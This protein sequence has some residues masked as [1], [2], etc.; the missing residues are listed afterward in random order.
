MSF[1]HARRAF[2]GVIVVAFACG[3][4][5]VA[6]D[7][8]QG[9]GGSSA[10][11]AGG[12][13]VG[14]GGVG[15]GAGTSGAGAAGTAGKGGGAGA[16]SG[17]AGGAGAGGSAGKAGAG[18]SAPLVCDPRFAFSPSKPAPGVPFQVS[19]TDT[20]PYTNVAMLVTGP[21][22]PATSWVGVSGSYTWTWAVTGHAAGVSTFT[23]QKDATAPGKG[24]TLGTCQVEV[25]APGT[26]GSG[27]VG[28]SGGSGTGGGF[29]CSP[30][31]AQPTM[32]TKLLFDPSAAHPGDTL[33][34]LAKT[35]NGT[36]AANAPKMTLEIVT[37]AGAKTHDALLVTNVAP[38]DSGWYFAQAQLPL[39][40][41]C[42]TAIV[43]GKPEAS[44]KLTVTPRPA[45]PAGKGVYKVITH[46]QFTC[47]EQ[48]DWG[49][50]LHVE[51]RDENG[52]GVP[53]ATVDFFLP[54]TTDAA[55]I[56]NASQHAVPKSV[57]TDASGKY[58]DYFWWPSSG[59][60]LLVLKVA[61]AG[62]PSDVATEITSG[63]WETDAKGC[64][65]CPGSSPINVYG[66]WSHRIVF[67]RDPAATQACLV[68]SDH[69]GMGNGC[70]VMHAYHEPG[71]TSCWTP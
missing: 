55:T 8:P 42:V 65:Y 59:N 4:D 23:F 29:P 46:H 39:G 7:A 61:V 58:D 36:K 49:N 67:Q 50:E 35:T 27:G 19:F 15:G 2:L 17:G 31:T 57:T 37:A 24:V 20:T 41:V 26:G 21:G 68:P 10:G 38:D 11:A 44:G 70:A 48:P 13:G 16:G 64:K 56:K 62:A 3:G 34:V 28:G 66:H 22:T 60:G 25:A 53:G 14:A 45:G 5:E 30:A 32:G 43:N 51:V 52:K 69:A 9:D 63:W 47:Q 6:S 18:G 40:D 1:A 54:D 12:G 71:A 33:S